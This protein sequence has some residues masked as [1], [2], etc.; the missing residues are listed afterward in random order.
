MTA[1]AVILGPD[2]DRRDLADSKALTHA[3]RDA[4]R[5]RITA[6]ASAWSIGWAGH[7]EIDRLNIHWATLLAMRRAFLALGVVPDEVL[8]DGRFCPDVG[9]P[10]TAVV[11]GDRLIAEIQAA[12][13][14]AKT[15][16]DAWMCNHARTEP[17]YLFEKH[18]GYPTREHR[19]R[20]A[21]FGP[22]RIQRLSFAASTSGSHRLASGAGSSVAE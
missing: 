7:R 13:I 17:D 22:S 20:I 19:C 21:A 4:L 11:H 3:R 1:A 10:C 16:R 2:F 9:V 6:R 18:K 12:S 15:I 14:L 5:T 8:V